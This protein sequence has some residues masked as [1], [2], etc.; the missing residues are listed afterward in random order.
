[1]ETR[2]QIAFTDD[3]IEKLMGNLLRYGVLI[4]AIVICIGATFYFAQHGNAIP[5]YRKFTGEPK[6]FTE[7]RSVWTSLLNGRG[8]SII[9]MGLFILIATPIARIIFSVVGYVL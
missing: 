8:R 3:Q 9:Q 1:M 5:N 6:R 7:F 2:K 4:A